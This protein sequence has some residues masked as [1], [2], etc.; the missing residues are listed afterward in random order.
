MSSRL[1]DVMRERVKRADEAAVTAETVRREMEDRV[2]RAE[3]AA[4]SAAQCGR[5]HYSGRDQER[6]DERAAT[7][8]S[9]E[10]RVKELEEKLVAEARAH[11]ATRTRLGEAE[12]RSRSKPYDRPK[13]VRNPRSRDRQE[14]DLTAPEPVIDLTGPETEG[15]GKIYEEV[16]F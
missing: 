4:A 11:R 3:K 5:R 13:V 8:S 10:A 14:I 7:I 9:L 12:R 15:E 16:W 6:E 2:Y 1:L